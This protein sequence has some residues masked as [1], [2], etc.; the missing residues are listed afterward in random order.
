MI[1]ILNETL[2]GKGRLDGDA[3]LHACSGQLETTN[4]VIQYSQWHLN[5]NSLHVSWSAICS[6]S[7]Q[8]YSEPNISQTYP[9]IPI[10]APC[11]RQIQSATCPSNISKLEQ[12]IHFQIDARK[13]LASYLATITRKFATL[14]SNP[15]P[16]FTLGP[17]RHPDSIQTTSSCACPS[18]AT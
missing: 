12:E 11:F 13:I 1:L 14:I 7:A 10:T 6:R 16:V 17:R 18:S 2:G 9:S 8:R 5:S 4:T 3:V 15:T